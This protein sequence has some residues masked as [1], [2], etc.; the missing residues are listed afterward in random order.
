MIKILIVGL[1]NIYGGI[2]NYM[3]NVINNIDLNHFTFD[4]LNFADE[5]IAFEDEFVKKG[6]NIIRISGRKKNFIKYKKELNEL[7]KKNN[8]DIIHFH[9]M[10]F[11]AFERIRWAIKYTNAKII[12]HSHNAGFG[13]NA[14]IHTRLLHYLG[15]IILKNKSFYKVSCGND[16]GKWLYREGEFTVLNNGIDYE[17]YKFNVNNR[18]KI[19]NKLN[20]KHDEVVIGHTGRLELQKNHSFLVEVF[21]EYYKKNNKCK[22]ILVGDGSLKEKIENKVSNLKISNNVIFIGFTKNVNEY[23]SAF[24]IFCLPSL[25]EGL[26]ISLVEAQVNGLKCFCSTNID[27][28]SDITGNTYFLSLKKSPKE[29]AEE[30]IN[31]NI[32]RD[33]DILKDINKDYF[34]E[35]SVKKLEKYYINISK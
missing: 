34:I 24:D 26:S 14:K 30:I 27:Q 12:V 7:Y 21:Y 20:I 23:Y 1:S 3:N 17:K 22:L 29:W 19:R 4:F 35:N 16:A 5:K 31:R 33:D 28:T 25:F 6:F 11:E 9:V 2:E 18:N 13:S 10:S 15:K 8:Y 32:K